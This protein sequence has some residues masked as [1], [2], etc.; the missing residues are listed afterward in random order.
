MNSVSTS[1]RFESTTKPILAVSEVKRKSR[2]TA[3][4]VLSMKKELGASQGLASTVTCE[5]GFA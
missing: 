1:R 5:V 4:I 3:S 2:S